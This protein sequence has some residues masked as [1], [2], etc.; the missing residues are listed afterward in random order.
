MSR[1]KRRRAH[2]EDGAATQEKPMKRA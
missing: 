1:T 2:Q